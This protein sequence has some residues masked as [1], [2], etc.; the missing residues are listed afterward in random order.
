MCANGVK[1]L[2]STSEANRNSVDDDGNLLDESK[3][4]YRIQRVILGEEQRCGNDM[5]SNCV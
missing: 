4:G 1:N 5:D 3:Q 2:M